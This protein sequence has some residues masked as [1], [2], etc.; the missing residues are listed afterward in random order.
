MK[1]RSWIILLCIFFMRL[2]L[3]V[4]AGGGDEAV[5]T[6]IT[7]CDILVVTLNGKLATVR[8]IGIDCPEVHDSDKLHRDAVRSG[9]SAPAIQALGQ[10][11]SDFV[12]SLVGLGGRITLEYDQQRRDPHGRLLAFV[13]LADGRLLNE[14]IICEGYSPAY[15]RF[16]FRRDYMKRFR[17]C[18]QHAQAEGKKRWAT[19]EV[20]PSDRV[21]SRQPGE[22]VGE[23]RGNRRSRIYHLPRCPGYER[24]SAKNI[25]SF[26]SEGEAQREGYRKARNCP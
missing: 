22:Y 21:E 2:A 4:S 19:K 18:A 17:R 14:V 11:A 24:L 26:S 5:L 10:Q 15:T 1:V 13:R 23:V 12:K 6:Q 20:A 7:D 25:V 9:Q 3:P 8:L 16:P